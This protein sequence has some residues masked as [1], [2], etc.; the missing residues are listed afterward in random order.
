MSRYKGDEGF[1]WNGI[2]IWFRSFYKFTMEPK[3]PKEPK[4][5]QPTVE[6][7]VEL[8]EVRDIGA[9]LYVEAEQLSTE[10]LALE[11]AR[12]LRI[13]D[14]RIMPIVSSSWPA[15]LSL[16]NRTQL[17]VTYVIQF[18]G[19]ISLVSSSEGVRLTLS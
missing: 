18:L 12:V 8:G 7:E 13:L 10:E 1:A 5:D 3:E 9:D 17:Y 2:Q 4:V 15:L 11:G 19:V 16:S 6:K 14:W